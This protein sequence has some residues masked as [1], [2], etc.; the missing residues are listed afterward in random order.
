MS[1]PEVW[2]P[3]VWM[4][5]H[6]MIEKMHEE[7]YPHIYKSF[8]KF[9][10][11]IC[12]YLPCPQCSGDATRFLA[13]IKVEDLKTKNDFKNMIYIFH[14]YVNT[15]KRKPLFNYANINMYKN[16]KLI[17]IF[18]NFISNYNTKGNLSLITES[19][20]RHFIINDSKKWFSQNINAFA[21]KPKIQL[22]NKPKQPDSKEESDT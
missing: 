12:M 4:L 13:K 21:Y 20:R 5:F 19:F 22:E 17:P 2:G 14:N 18:N 11:N 16:Y 7:A 9:I 1:P 3:P 10:Q 6:T 8:F 15:K